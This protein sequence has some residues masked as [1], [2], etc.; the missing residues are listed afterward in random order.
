[1]GGYRVKPKNVAH[2]NAIAVGNKK[3]NGSGLCWNR[4]HELSARRKPFGG[5]VRFQKQEPFPWS[6]NFFGIRSRI[7]KALKPAESKENP[8]NRK[9]ASEPGS[10][11]ARRMPKFRGR[12]RANKL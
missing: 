5:S 2:K 11:S 1:M 10:T 7:M 8:L 4:L 9:R 3:S 6:T 12:R